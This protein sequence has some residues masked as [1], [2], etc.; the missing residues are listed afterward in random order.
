MKS[1]RFVSIIAF[2]AATIG[3]TSCGDNSTPHRDE[4]KIAAYYQNID[5][6]SRT[7]KRDLHDLNESMIVKLVGYKAMLSNPGKGYYLTDP[8]DSEMTIRT[9]YSGR[10][11]KGN[12]GLNREHVWPNSRG[13]NLVEDDIHMVRPTLT[14]EN[15]SRGNSFYV[16]G[17]CTEHDGWDPAMEDF[18]MES[19]RGD[20]ARIIFYCAIANTSLTIIDK[21]TDNTSNNTMGKLSDLLK[22]NL[23]YPVL[24]RE[25]IRNEGAQTLQGNR[26]PFID[27]PEY[28]C[29]IWGNT[30][31]NTRKICGIN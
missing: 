31:S 30:N 9:F 7:L 20:A 12:G 19:Y 13:G 11:N 23:Q 24:D 17:K 29:K 25:Y 3:L 15:G 14:T 21:A 27:H 6:E 22:W 2:I 18:G 8:G 26:N 10:S 16:E 28:A 5:P 1:K 4:K